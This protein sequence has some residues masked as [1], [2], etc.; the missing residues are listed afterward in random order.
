MKHHGFHDTLW[1]DREHM[2]HHGFHDTLLDNREDMK[3]HGF[4]DTLWDNRED[5]K[6]HGFHEPNCHCECNSNASEC[7]KFPGLVHHTTVLLQY[8]YTA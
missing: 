8:Y 1:D 6:H 7:V 3:H 5:M 4:H 2:K